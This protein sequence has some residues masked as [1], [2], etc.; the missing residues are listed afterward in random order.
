MISTQI[1]CDSFAPHG[2][3][4]TTFS[5][6]YPR[7]IHSELMT[8]RVFSRN[9]SSSRA[10]PVKKMLDHIR[11]NPATPVWWGKNQPGMQ[12]KEE[13]DAFSKERA[14]Q[15][16]LDACSD[17]VR[18][19]QDMMD[20]GVH[21][22]IANRLTEPFAHINTIVTATEWDNFYNLRCHPDAQP[23]IQ[24]LATTMREQMKNSSPRSL[25]WDEWHLP[26]IQASELCSHSI[27]NLIKYCVARCCR[28]S[29]MNH[30]GTSPDPV[31][32][33]DLYDKL[34]AS[35]HMSPF[36]HAAKP[37]PQKENWSGNYKGWIQ[38][39]KLIS[40]ESVFKGISS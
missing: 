26:Y 25:F 39:R 36:E 21:K 31:K 7:F 5:L 35:G 8:H 13:L 34:L 12:A 22:Q 23:E 27:D 38:Y 17:A 16:W 37:S 11:A 4:L 3:R 2:A 28:V 20:I 9:A 10:V 40:G 33:L 29:Y 6:I 15:K 30:D 19:A 32:D 24:V 14:V 18:H 1:V